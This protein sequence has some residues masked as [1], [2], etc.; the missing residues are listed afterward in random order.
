MP[1]AAIA[2]RLKA[3]ST[4]RNAQ[5]QRGNWPRHISI[6]VAEMRP[7]SEGRIFASFGGRIDLT[8]EESSGVSRTCA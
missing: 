3:R 1:L 8:P 5:H 6:P 2:A 7:F 4:L